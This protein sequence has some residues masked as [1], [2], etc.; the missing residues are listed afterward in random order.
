MKRSNTACLLFVAGCRITTIM[1]MDSWREY[2]RLSSGS[3]SSV[4]FCTSTSYLIILPRNHDSDA[5]H[6]SIPHACFI[7]GEQLR[8]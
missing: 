3:L 2:H 4:N 1:A 6:T 8:T 5:V 7:D